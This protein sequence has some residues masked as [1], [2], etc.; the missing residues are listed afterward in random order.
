M[1]KIEQ[2]GNDAIATILRHGTRM[3]VFPAM[4]LQAGEIDTL[5]VT[6]GEITYSVYEKE[7]ITVSAP[8]VTPPAKTVVPT[9]KPKVVL[10]ETNKSMG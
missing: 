5:E 9:A 7:I 8:V 4:T 6:R 10:P 3:Q 1:I 2:V